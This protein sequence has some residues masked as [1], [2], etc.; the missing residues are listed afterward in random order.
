MV[1]NGVKNICYDKKIALKMLWI[2]F[3]VIEE[4]Y[5]NKEV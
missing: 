4:K 2:W 5:K 3:M 1:I